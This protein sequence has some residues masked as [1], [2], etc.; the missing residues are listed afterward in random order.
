MSMTVSSPAGDRHVA[1]AFIA[2][3]IALD[4][5]FSCGKSPG[6]RFQFRDLF[7]EGASP[8]RVLIVGAGGVGSAAA[9]IAARRHFFERLVLADYDPARAQRTV[10]SLGDDRFV[11][12]RVDASSAGQVAALC[13]AHGITH[14]LKPG[15]PALLMHVVF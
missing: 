4:K 10:G 13:R 2:E 12:A 7:L 11:A 14:V 5:R 3:L 15:D 6:T 1:S 8:M 9:G